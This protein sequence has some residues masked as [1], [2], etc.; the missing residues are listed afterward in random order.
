MLFNTSIVIPA[1]TKTAR[2]DGKWVL[3]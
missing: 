3:A 2:D 1:R